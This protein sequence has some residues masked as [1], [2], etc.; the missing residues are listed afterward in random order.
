VTTV[1]KRLRSIGEGYAP[2][3]GRPLRG[4]V[5]V[6]GGYLGVCGGLVG[7]ASLTGRRAPEQP[8]ARDVVLISVATHKLSRLLAK[9]S[10]TSPLRAPFARYERT[11]NTGEMGEQARGSGATHTVGELLTCPFCLSVWVATG[12]A[13]GLVFAPRL[14]RLVAATFTAVTASDALQ[15][16]YVALQQGVAHKH[17]HP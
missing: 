4:Y 5:M 7:V 15:L 1:V 8:T 6:L 16:A 13:A 10:V 12:L 11:T 17:T 3:R 14:T 9:Q 2:D